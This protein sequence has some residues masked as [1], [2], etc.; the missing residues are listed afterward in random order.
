MRNKRKYDYLAH[1]MGEEFH[2]NNWWR[3]PD[4][5]ARFDDILAPME[6]I[7]RVGEYPE[8]HR[9]W[10]ATLASATPEGS[11]R[12]SV[13]RRV[14]LLSGLADRRNLEALLAQELVAGLH[15][16]HVEWR[17][18]LQPTAN[19]AEDLLMKMPEGVP[20]DTPEWR[21]SAREYLD[22]YYEG[23]CEPNI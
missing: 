16:D 14:R 2:R 11:D 3:F 5:W 23:L 19:H 13:G 18:N 6:V 21:A 20:G 12:D 7:D 22:S 8:A 9:A 1:R 15:G 4:L 17:W 10:V